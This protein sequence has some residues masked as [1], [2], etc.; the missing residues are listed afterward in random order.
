MLFNLDFAN[1]TIYQASFSFFKIFD[2]YL[3]IPAVIAKIFNP[4][5]KL[6]IPIGISTKEDKAEME[7]HPVIVEANL[8]LQ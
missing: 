4:M 7:K 1:N 6:A 5:A 8:F 3:L 2:L